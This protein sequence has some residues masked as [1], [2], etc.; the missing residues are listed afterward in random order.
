MSVIIEQADP[1]LQG[2]WFPIT[3]N[4]TNDELTDAQNIELSL[5]LINPSETQPP[6]V[7]G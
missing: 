6:E 1:A 3:I 2:E 4:I 5:N 7:L